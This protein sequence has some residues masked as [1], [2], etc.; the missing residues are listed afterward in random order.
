MTRA[1]AA[2]LAAAALFG[3]L[4]A[5]AADSGADESAALQEVTVT[6]QRVA[7]NLQST[8]ISMTALSGSFIEKFD[9]QR[10][11]SLETVSPNL[12]FFSGTGGSSS[13]VS[14]FMR[15]VGQFDFLLST[16]PAV[17]LYVDG[18]YLA[19]TFGTNLELNDIERVELLR[20][21]QGTLFGKN[22]IGGAINITTL[23]PTGSGRSDFRASGRQL[24]FVR[25]RC[26]H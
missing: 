6:A 25:A 24:R 22:N 5:Q 26:L 11:T 15:G 7:E 21:P 8:P 1:T 23:T 4:T 14:A 2:G 10:V 20:G 19:R 18:V 13:Q 16:D 12:V 17:G 9:V 3:S